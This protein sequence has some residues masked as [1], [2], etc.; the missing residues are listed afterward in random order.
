MIYGFDKHQ[1][2]RLVVLMVPVQMVDIEPFP[3]FVLQPI[4][5]TVWVNFKPCEVVGL[6]FP[7]S[8]AHLDFAFRDMNFLLNRMEDQ[9]FVFPVDV[10]DIHPCRLSPS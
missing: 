10:L 4:G 8:H 2:R 5:V 6:K 7:T 3:E 9:L 1:I